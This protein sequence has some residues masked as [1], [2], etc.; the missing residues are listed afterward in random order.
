MNFEGLTRKVQ[1]RPKKWKQIDIKQNG[2][3]KKKYKIEEA[4]FIIKW[5][6]RITH[7][8]NKTNKIIRKYF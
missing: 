6:G 1:I 4:L 8:G 3:I 5:G 2:K 7:S